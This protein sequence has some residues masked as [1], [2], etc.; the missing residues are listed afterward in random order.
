MSLREEKKGGF[1]SGV[2]FVAVSIHVLHKENDLTLVAVIFYENLL[3]PELLLV[4]WPPRNCLY[5]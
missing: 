1:F 2:K 4:I 5:P 3:S